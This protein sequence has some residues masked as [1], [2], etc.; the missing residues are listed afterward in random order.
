M[1][2]TRTPLLAGNWKLNGLKA[3]ALKLARAVADGC[4]SA[5]GR[6]VMIAP[7]F[8][9]LAAVAE[10]LAGSRVTLGGQDLYWES[11]GA[12]TG[13]V[14]APMLRDVGCSHVII[15]HSER[16]QYFAETDY[17]V[18]K[19]VSAAVGAGLV[20]VMCVGETL[21]QRDA[22]V[23]FDVIRRQVAG[24]LVELPEEAFPLLVIAYEPVWAIGTGRTATP[25]QAEEVHARIRTLLAE[26]LNPDAA[27]AIRILYGGSVKPDNIDALMACANV[28]GALVGGA[29]LKADDFLRIVHFRE[30][31]N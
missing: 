7:P 3:D 27:A 14:S 21:E 6:E 2:R 30:L 12:F 8:P 28:D 5:S 17:T 13:E 23:T 18:A 15:G 25:E 26:T 20:P 29:S 16:R 22:G 19:K 9:V 31:S 10:A 11:A 1:S 4:N 24:G